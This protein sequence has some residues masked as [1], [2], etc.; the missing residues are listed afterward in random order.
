MRTRSRYD[1]ATVA[2]IQNLSVRNRDLPSG[3][4][5]GYTVLVNGTSTSYPVVLSSGDSVITDDPDHPA[6]R[7]KYVDHVKHKL[8][9]YRLPY[10]HT[11]NNLTLSPV[12][13]YEYT[14]TGLAWYYREGLQNGEI[15]STD[16][17][18][19]YPKT[20]DDL[21][22]E[23]SDKFL[24]VNEVDSLLNAVESPEL[25]E[26]GHSII[27]IMTR[28]RKGKFRGTDIANLYLGYSFGIAPLIADIRRVNNALKTLKNR[29]DAAIK[30]YGKMQVVTARCYGSASIPD[31]FGQTSNSSARGYKYGK[32][33]NTSTRHAW[34]AV[35][36]PQTAP[37]RIVGLRGK[38]TVDYSSDAFKRLDYLISRFVATGPASFIWERIPFSF[39][40]DWFVDLSSIMGAL[41]N[42][43]TGTS[44]KIYEGWF[45]EKTDMLVGA[46]SHTEGQ[47]SAGVWSP[48]WSSN[49][50]GEQIALNAISTY[51]REPISPSLLVGLSSRF[52]KKQASYTAALLYQMVA[53]LKR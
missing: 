26:Y 14:D 42:A 3:T 22:R 15:R 43:L 34:H 25:V 19:S 17:N 16:I 49:A 44:K 13:Q 18:V 11:A 23:A 38:R 9:R 52:G 1:D 48:I 28:A 32:L 8:T 7:I 21:I 6:A 24:N 12:K 31:S 36:Y 5:S 50:D 39:V 37:V 41:D 35:I 4:W 51:H 46:Y 20:V 45:S 33:G 29:M 47:P 53:K 10:A 27:D 40:V 30:A 2:Y